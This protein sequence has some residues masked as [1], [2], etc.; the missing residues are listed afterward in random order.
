LAWV[1]LDSLIILVVYI[2]SV[3]L[4]SSRSSADH[5][6]DE[7]I[8]PGTPRLATSLLIFLASAGV[9]VVATPFMVANSAEIAEIT[10]L[11]ATFIGT[12]LVALVTSLPEV[13]TTTAAIRIG[14]HDMAIA[15]LF[16]SNM[17]NMFALGLTD[18]FYTPGRFMADIDPAFLMVGLFGLLMTV[19]GLIGNIANVER[20]ILSVEIDSLMLFLVYLFGMWLLFQ[21]GV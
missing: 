21:R 17:F 18:F 1:G 5:Q 11:G 3:R 2:V 14:A 4:I 10:G 16:G 20:R 8:P 9:L 19:I 6:A 15:N 13:V 7:E 12:T